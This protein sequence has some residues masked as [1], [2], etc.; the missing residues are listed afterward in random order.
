MG[1]AFQGKPWATGEDFG[2]GRQKNFIY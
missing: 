2:A 1:K